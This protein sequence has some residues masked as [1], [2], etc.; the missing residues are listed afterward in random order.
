MKTKNTD[1]Y[2]MID[3]IVG[4]VIMFIIGYYIG[5]IIGLHSMNTRIQREAVSRGY[6]T[7]NTDGTNILFTWKETK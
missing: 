1:G 3:Y 6:A 7:F 4:C 5:S 2:F